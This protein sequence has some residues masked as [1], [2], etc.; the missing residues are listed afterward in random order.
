MTD[1]EL[2]KYLPRE[3]LGEYEPVRA[4]KERSDRQVIL[5]RGRDGSS[6]VLKRASDGSLDA[7]IYEA[8]R[9]LDGQGVPRIM[10]IY[11]DGEAC[12]VLREYVEGSTLLEL[13]RSRGPLSAAETA[14]L[15]AQIAE[16]LERL[17]KMD[18][19][20][21]HRDIKAE[22]VV[23]TPDRGCV[24]IDFGIARRFSESES[25]DTQII[26]TGFAA[27][28]EQF[29]YS[30]TDP[31]SDIYSLG[32]LLHE[33]S[34]GEYSLDR[35]LVPAEL[36]KVVAKC[37]R[38]DPED[39][40][41]SAKQVRR[42]LLR[43]KNR[44]K[45]LISYFAAALAASALL[46]AV[47]FCVIPEESRIYSFASPLIGSEVA[48]QLGKDVR[49]ITRGDL[50]KITSL[51]IAGTYPFDGWDRIL[52]HGNEFTLDGKYFDA[53]SGGTVDTLEDIPNLKNLTELSLCNQKITDL[54]PLSGTRIE[55]LA[56]HGNKIEDLTPLSGCPELRALYIS[57]NP[58]ADL[59]PLK[60]L[61]K[62]SRLNI[63]ATL[64]KDLDALADFP[65]LTSLEVHD[66]PELSMDGVERLSRVDFLSVRPVSAEILAEIGGMTRLRSLYVWSGEEIE[67]LS[68]ISGLTGLTNLYID[69]SNLGSIDGIQ[70]LTSLTVLDMRG[71]LRLDA[72]P[73]AAL[74]ALEK[75]DLRSL[76]SDD[77]SELKDLKN[78]QF[79]TARFEDSEAI[80]KALDGRS[81]SISYLPS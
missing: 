63:G 20:V 52:I 55:N 60:G 65:A 13:Y 49:T 21:I 46:A 68:A 33:I 37:T 51:Q 48:R 14:E 72:G 43:V 34:T 7:G 47:I 18:P 42:A 70:K 75:L 2:T 26:G 9:G 71:G 38:F 59:S 78:L 66:C 81:C 57:D 45:L 30:Q 54:A 56:L 35:G 40:Y 25:R 50:E 24:L 12:C 61:A 16:T 15:G 5:L 64:V 62:L 44:L 19:P 67:D 4:L 3:L 31:R 58:V 74:T 11:R 36:G 27:A 28:P 77:W 29:G 1:G 79:I 23:L 41:S 17:H 22:N 76:Y 73:I 8:V 39:R 10:G 80:Q 53:L 32:V 69:F 6:A